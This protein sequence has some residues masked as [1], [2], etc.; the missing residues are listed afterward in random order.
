MAFYSQNYEI[1]LLEKLVPME[2][3]CYNFIKYL[4]LFGIMDEDTLN[5]FSKLFDAEN[6]YKSAI[7]F[8]NHCLNY[9][10]NQLTS[11]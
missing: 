10:L 8:L 6:K 1:W 9:N 2:I 7:P 3:L 5:I 11:F 4:F